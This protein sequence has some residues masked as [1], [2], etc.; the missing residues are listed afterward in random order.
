MEEKKIKAFI[1]E[2]MTL[3][4]KLNQSQQ[5]IIK[6]KLK[7]GPQNIKNN[8]ENLSFNTSLAK[9]FTASVIG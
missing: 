1:S 8:L 2:E 5:K 6:N 4:K 7:K 3:K 9:S